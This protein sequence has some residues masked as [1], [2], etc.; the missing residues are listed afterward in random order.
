MFAGNTRD[1]RKYGKVS[2]TFQRLVSMSNLHG[3]QH[4][5]EWT[6]NKPNMHSKITIRA[7]HQN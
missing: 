7:L 2:F 3:K 1:L 5:G 6:K 4:N